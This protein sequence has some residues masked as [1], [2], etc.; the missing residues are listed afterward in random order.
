[1]AKTSSKHFPPVTQRVY[2][3]Y[4]YTGVEFFQQLGLEIDDYD[5]AEYQVITKEKDKTLVIETH[6]D[7]FVLINGSWTYSCSTISKSNE[8]KHF[9]VGGPLAG[10]VKASSQAPD[11]SVFNNSTSGC[12]VLDNTLLIWNQIMTRPLNG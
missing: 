12:D 7:H 11:Y 4:S 1:M 5:S 9:C 3:K 2:Y 6:D 10:Q 8:K